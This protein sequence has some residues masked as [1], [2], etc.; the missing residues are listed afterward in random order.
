MILQVDGKLYRG[1]RPV[2]HPL[3]AQRVK[4][5]ILL[6]VQPSEFAEIKAT[7]ARVISLEGL[8]EDAKEKKELSPAWVLSAP[9]SFSEIYFTG[10]TQSRLK[11]ILDE[12]DADM[13]VGNVLVHCEH[14][15][16]R[17]GLIIAAY[18]VRKWVVERGG[19]GGSEE[20]WLS[21]LD[22]FWIE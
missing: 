7:F 20:T 13:R 3:L 16:D 22:Q 6:I 5:N 18:R 19:D 10:I 11:W 17:T 14:G 1:A 12:I 9:I 2:K 4:K 15:Q 21:R 8:A